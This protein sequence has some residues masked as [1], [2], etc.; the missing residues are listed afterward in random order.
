LDPDYR[1]I[2]KYPQTEETINTFQ[3]NPFHH[4]KDELSRQMK[5]LQ[6]I[7]SIYSVEFEKR[8]RPKIKEMSLSTTRYA[9]TL[10][11]HDPDTFF[12]FA[13]D[14]NHIPFGDLRQACEDV[15]S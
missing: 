4:Q 6:E 2:L 11:Y 7:S 1:Y 12:Y 8:R 14:I 13:L 9:S 15:L 3:I 5:S 10:G